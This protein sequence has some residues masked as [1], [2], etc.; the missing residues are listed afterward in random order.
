VIRL[1]ALSVAL[2]ATDAR[3]ESGVA[4]PIEA[5]AHVRRPTLP[6]PSNG[7]VL[8]ESDGLGIPPIEVRD[9]N[10]VVID[11]VLYEVGYGRGPLYAWVPTAPLELGTIEV[12]LGLEG[13]PAAEEP[14]TIEVVAPFEPGPPELRSETS[15]TWQATPFQDACCHTPLNEPFECFFV[16]QQCSILVQP[17]LSTA[18][19]QAVLN[20]YLFRAVPAGTATSETDPDFSPLESFHQVA[21]FVPSDS[22][23]IEVQALNLATQQV[24]VYT[25][26]EGCASHD[27]RQVG[28]DIEIEL[29]PKILAMER[30][31]IPP[32]AYERDWCEINSAVCESETSNECGLYEHVC[33]DGPLPQVWQQ[34]LD[35]RDSGVPLLDGGFRD[36]GAM[37]SGRDDD[38]VDAEMPT[39]PIDASTGPNA[40]ADGCSCS[41]IQAASAS[42]HALAPMLGLALLALRRGRQEHAKLTSRS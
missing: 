22:Y 29:D 42:S 25:D 2:L 1:T 24:H 17:G 36:G 31:P 3:A 27:N 20:Q 41:T 28:H 5:T 32:P 16:L 6:I 11:G 18:A 33:N 7:A 34:V 4:I 8:L 15:A 13:D 23:C 40:R 14:T 21:F 39:D 12:T 9:E 19:T 30:C 26:L 35:E 37:D 38:A 10:G